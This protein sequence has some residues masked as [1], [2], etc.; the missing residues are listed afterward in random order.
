MWFLVIW[1][2]IIILNLVVVFIQDLMNKSSS[3]VANYLYLRGM[4]RAACGQNIK[5][6]TG[7]PTL[8]LEKSLLTVYIQ[9]NVFNVLHSFIT[10]FFLF[11][12][13]VDDFFLVSSKNVQLFPTK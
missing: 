6:H 2:F 7:E 5:V 1:H 4:L 12:Q 3:L 10:L 11:Q 13:A 8:V 9:N